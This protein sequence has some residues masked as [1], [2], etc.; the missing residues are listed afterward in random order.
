MNFIEVTPNMIMGAEIS[1]VVKVVVGTDQDI[2]CICQDSKSAEKVAIS[3]ATAM[4]REYTNNTSCRVFREILPNKIKIL[5]QSLGR[6]ING[7]VIK[8]ATIEWLPVGHA[9]NNIKEHVEDSLTR[10]NRQHKIRKGWEDQLESVHIDVV[11]QVN[12]HGV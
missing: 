3:L 1:Y 9:Y 11:D 2:L 5:K 8:L 6:I 10:K 7:T 4:E 12:S